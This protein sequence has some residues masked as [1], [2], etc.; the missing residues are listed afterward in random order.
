MQTVADR[1][2]RLVWGENAVGG[3]Y[4]PLTDRDGAVRAYVFNYVQNREN[5]PA[6]ETI[7]ATIRE[8]RAE[9]RVYFSRSGGRDRLFPKFYAD[10]ERRLGR[11]GAVV[12]AA[13]R[14]DFPILSVHHSIHPFFLYADA[15][16]MQ[17]RRILAQE[18]LALHRVYYF[19][20]HELYF[21]FEANSGKS[22]LINADSMRPE[23][24]EGVFE[25]VTWP[26]LDPELEALAKRAWS[27]YTEEGPG[28]IPADGV[29]ITHTLNL[30]IPY[31]KLIPVVDYTYWCVP[32]AMTM[33]AG[34]W[35]N[36]VQGTGTVGG[37]GRII[38]FWLVNSQSNNVP[39]FI[40]EIIDP[41]TQTWSPQG[42]LG[43]LNNTN[44]Y[45]FSWTRTEQGAS[46]D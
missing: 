5:L 10:L 27:E 33:L 39:N 4:F 22:I 32:T 15:A 30:L 19:G 24:P 29:C 34:F 31:Y 18:K 12:V 28:L 21:G 3:H 17:A 41:S 36:Y 25:R 14:E 7:F 37:F 23:A 46:N 11:L 16:V 35:D 40:D 26:M 43:T 20:P 8:L 45:N 38:D 2:A 6:V 44:G 1:H 9:H 13:S 42:F